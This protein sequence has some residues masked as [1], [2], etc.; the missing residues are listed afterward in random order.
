[1]FKCLTRIGLAALFTATLGAVAS[2]A[3]PP[4]AAD[5]AGTII[6][7]SERPQGQA[8]QNGMAEPD[9]TIFLSTSDSLSLSGHGTATVTVTDAASNVTGGATVFGEIAVGFFTAAFSGHSLQVVRFLPQGGTEFPI[10]ASG[11]MT[12][13]TVLVELTGGFDC[14]GICDGTQNGKIT[15]QLTVE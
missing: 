3:P 9:G 14:S 6:T 13:T 12:G 8:E 10:N 4:A 2:L 11:L 1:M 7:G 5:W 15:F